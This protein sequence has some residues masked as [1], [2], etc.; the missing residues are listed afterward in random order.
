MARIVPFVILAAGLIALLFWR[1]GANEPFYVSGFI[2]AHEVRVGSR[3]GGRV[4]AVPAEEGAF[5]AAGDL[6]VELEPFTI[7]EEMARARAELAAQQAQLAQFEAGFRQEDIAQARAVRDAA[8]AA[9]DKAQAGPRPLEIR[10]L[11]DAVAVAQAE[12]AFADADFKRRKE[13]YEAKQASQ[14]EYDASQRAYA[15]ALARADQARDELALAREG[16]RAEEIAEARAL[17]AQRQADLERLEAGYRAEEIAQARARVAAAR[18]EVATIERRLT[19]LSVTS[20]CACRVEA[21]DLEPGDLVSANAPIMTLIDPRDLWI[22]AYIPENRLDVAVGE[23]VSIRVD[24]FPERRFAGHISFVA[25]RAEF[26]PANVQT[27]EE[28]V[29]QMFRIKV[30]LDEGQDVLQAGM[31][32]DIFP[33]AAAK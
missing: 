21:I 25:R 31:A 18:A 24:A 29:K 6:L 1:G 7:Q 13:L 14:E 12:L 3:V 26:T 15:V 28:R 10:F 33:A 17:L 5:V 16:T 2:E 19:E 30:D 8:Q 20:P 27:P 11:E 9:L 4:H 22:R 32:A 23:K